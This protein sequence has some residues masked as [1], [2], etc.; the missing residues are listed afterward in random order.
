MIEQ[1][2]YSILSIGY[3]NRSIGEFIDILKNYSIRFL[4]DLRSK[5]YSKYKMDFSGKNFEINLHKSGIKYVFM[6]DSL[7][8]LPPDRSCYTEEGYVDYSKVES[9]K[10]YQEGIKRLMT[11]HAKK[12]SLAIMCSESKPHECHRSKLVGETLE[13]N[14]IALQHINENGD[15]LSQKEVMTGL[16]SNQLSLFKSSRQTFTS[17]RKYLS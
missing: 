11:A 13:K 17:R 1:N 4:A 9:K 10:F 7:G 15:I 14:Q 3:G 6:G 12:V 2:G 16:K 8:G 5:P